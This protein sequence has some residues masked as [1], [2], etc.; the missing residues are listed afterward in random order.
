[1]TADRAGELVWFHG[2]NSG[3]LYLGEVLPGGDN[4]IGKFLVRPLTA[5]REWD[6]GFK[7]ASQTRNYL[8]RQWVHTDEMEKAT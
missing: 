2:E 3:R 5:I 4:G 1:M 7:H 6:A 8:W